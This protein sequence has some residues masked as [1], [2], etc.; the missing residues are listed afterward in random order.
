V[1]E[2]SFNLCFGQPESA[3]SEILYIFAAVTLEIITIYATFW[4]G[5]NEEI[6]IDSLRKIR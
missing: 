5:F 3:A 4:G 1:I 6:L 2:M